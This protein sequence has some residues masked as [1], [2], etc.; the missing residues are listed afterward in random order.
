F[1]PIGLL[2]IASYYLSLNHYICISKGNVE[3]SEIIFVNNKN[4]TSMDPPEKIFITSYFTYWSKYVKDCVRYY[5]KLFKNAEITVGGIYAT[6]MPEH[7]KKYTKCDK[8]FVGVMEE[9]EKIPL[10][11][12]YFE[13]K[14]GIYDFQIIHASRGCIKNCSFCGVKIIEPRFTYKNSIKNEIIKKNLIFYDNNLLANP[15]IENIL[16]EIISLRR[17]KK[18]NKCDAQA[19]IDKY[20]LVKKPHLANLLKEAGF[21]PIRISWDGGLNEKKI[22]EKALNILK[23]SGYS[24]SRDVYIFMLY[25][26]KISYEI[27]ELK[28]LQCW[29]WKVQIS[30]CRFRPLDKAYDNYL[31]YKKNQNGR[32]YYI[33][34]ECGWTDEKIRLFRQHVRQ[35][36]ICIRYRLSF[37]SKSI[38]KK[39]LSKNLTK[40]IIYYA[41]NFEFSDIQPILDK[42]KIDYWSP[43]LIDHNKNYLSFND[44]LEEYQ[45]FSGQPAKINNIYSSKFLK[46]WNTIQRKNYNMLKKLK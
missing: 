35:Q 1:Y 8:V 15:Y 37:Y 10:H 27:S 2:K 38:E 20:I 46:W 5:R 3:I 4:N 22:L 32:D 36:N 16:D 14:F 11:L 33:C 12:E 6:L 40:K 17:E 23:K 29:K 45:K 39:L 34:K 25:N 31:P 41:R 13:K 9:A 18:I 26:Y 44:I 21:K 7:C 30:D 43:N 42:L 28:R 19:G 24:I